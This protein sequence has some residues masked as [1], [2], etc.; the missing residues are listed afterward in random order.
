MTRPVS[1]HHL[2]QVIHRPARYWANTAAHWT[3]APQTRSPR[4][5]RPPRPGL[6]PRTTGRRRRA[7]QCSG[8]GGSDRAAAGLPGTP[9]SSPPRSPLEGTS[10]STP[11]EFCGPFPA[12]PPPRSTTTT[13]L[14]SAC[15]PHPSPNAPPDTPASDSSTPAASST[16]RVRV[17]PGKS[18]TR[19]P[20]SQ[21]VITRNPGLV[22]L[23]TQPLLNHARQHRW[24]AQPTA[25]CAYSIL[26]S[27][28]KDR[29]PRRPAQG[30]VTPNRSR[31]RIR[32]GSGT[33]APGLTCEF[34]G[35]RCWVRTNVG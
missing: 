5:P 20:D 1:H 32:P 34:D 18:L 13:T 24:R 11:D 14:P 29:Q 10:S 30:A 35:G 16:R 3:N 31:T 28:N 22:R 15:S 21:C 33:S 7:L 19:P 4:A 8:D 12:R 23:E 6:T 9:C 27:T 17:Q 26:T 2:V 25:P